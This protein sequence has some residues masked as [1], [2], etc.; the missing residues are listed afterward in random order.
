MLRCSA[1][2]PSPLLK[3]P[4]PLHPPAARN[5]SGLQVSV[6]LRLGNQDWARQTYPGKGHGYGVKDSLVD[7]G[8]L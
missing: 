7:I 8:G 2:V 1:L 4:Y 3:S 6:P 5:T